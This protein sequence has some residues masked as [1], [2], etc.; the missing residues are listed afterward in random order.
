MK[1]FL[2]KRIVIYGEVFAAGGELKLLSIIL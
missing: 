2:M 1:A